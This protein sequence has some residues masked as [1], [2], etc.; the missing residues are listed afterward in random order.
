MAES[1]AKAW[2]GAEARQVA[3]DRWVGGQV[4]LGLWVYVGVVD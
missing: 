2:L 1:E 3:L 4:L